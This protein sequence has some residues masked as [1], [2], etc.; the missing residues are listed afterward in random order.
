MRIGREKNGGEG[1]IRTHG[2]LVGYA[3][4]AKMCFRPLSHLTK[5]GAFP[6]VRAGPSAGRANAENKQR[7]CLSSNGFPDY[8]KRHFP[9]HQA[10]KNRKGCPF[11]FFEKFGR[12]TAVG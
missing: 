9:D 6:K 11:R 10:R 2:T 12:M 3:S 8:P 7:T 5:F 1:G 4:L